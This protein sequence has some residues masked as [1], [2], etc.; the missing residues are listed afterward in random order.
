MATTYRIVSHCAFSVSVCP[1]ELLRHTIRISQRHKATELSSMSQL[2]RRGNVQPG[3]KR[4]L[5]RNRHAAG[6]YLDATNLICILC[7][8][9]THVCNYIAAPQ[10]RILTEAQSHRVVQIVSKVYFVSGMVIDLDATTYLNLHFSV[11]LVTLCATYIAAPTKQESHTEAQSHRV[12]QIVSKSLLRNGMVID[13]GNN[14]LSAFLCAFIGCARKAW[15]F[16]LVER[17]NHGK[18]SFAM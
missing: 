14:I 6:D 11:C 8:L 18:C 16:S 3:A 12:V 5:L 10:S 7:A 4:G 13:L 2:V 1:H 15:Q 17:Y 9:V